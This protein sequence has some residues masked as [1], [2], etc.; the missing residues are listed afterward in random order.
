[1]NELILETYIKKLKKEHIIEYA[2]KNNIIL[3][4]NEVDIIYE[5][6]TK[7]FKIFYSGDPSYLFDKLKEKL[8]LNTYNTLI[9]LYKKAK[10]KIK[11]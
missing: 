9:M 3:Q 1:M 11:N 10:E 6:M 8:S 2:K 4:S 5:Y 7:Y